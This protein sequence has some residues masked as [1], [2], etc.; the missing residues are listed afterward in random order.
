MY[1]Y[2]AKLHWII[3]FSLKNI[4]TLGIYSIVKILSTRIYI[5][6]NKF[7]YKHGIVFIRETSINL[8]RI[9][10][11]TIDKSLLGAMLGYGNITITG[12]GGIVETIEDISK[13]NLLKRMIEEFINLQSF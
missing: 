10:S 3:N 13:P 1:A 9:E 11:I 12:N 2:E 5:N 6:D 7:V 8:N 4:L